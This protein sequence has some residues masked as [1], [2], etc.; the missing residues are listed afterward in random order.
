MAIIDK[1]LQLALAQADV[2]AAATYYSTNCIDLGGSRGKSIIEARGKVQVR[3]GT[4]YAGGTNI[5]FELVCSDTPWT[6]PAGTGATNVTVL[7]SSGVI[8]EAALTGDTIVFETPVPMTIP[9]RYFGVRAVGVGTHTGGT[10][11]I[12]IAVETQVGPY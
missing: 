1:S 3:V 8:L 9:K 11:D 4:V 12:N 7:G 5:T 2:R 6:A 10:H